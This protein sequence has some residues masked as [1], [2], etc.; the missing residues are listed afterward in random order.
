MAGDSDADAAI[1]GAPLW[2]QQDQRDSLSVPRSRGLDRKSL[3]GRY[4]RGDERGKPSMNEQPPWRP[5]SSILPS[6]FWVDR[7]LE[8]F[9]NEEWEALC[10]GCGQC[11]LVKLIDEDDERL[12]I[13]DV[14]CRGYN[15]AKGGCAVYERRKTVVPECIVLAPDTVR[16]SPHLFPPTCAYIRISQGADLPDWHPLRHAGDR[17]AM[18]AAGVAIAGK[19]VSETEVTDADLENRIRPWFSDLP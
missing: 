18:K 17:R 12:Y 16:E 19:V 14:A 10:D 8:D 11:C 4:P 1:G 2:R 5:D 3:G 15:C 6:E 9:S 7:R 13:T